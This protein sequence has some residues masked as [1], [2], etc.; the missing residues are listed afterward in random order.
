MSY[1]EENALQN[2]NKKIVLPREKGCPR[3]SFRHG[4]RQKVG[5]FHLASAQIRQLN[6]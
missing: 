6:E 5:A 4:N 1:N 3:H 2:M